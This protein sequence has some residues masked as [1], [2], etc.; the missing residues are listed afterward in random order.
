MKRGYQAVKYGYPAERAPLSHR[1]LGLCLYA[2]PTARGQTDVEMRYLRWTPNG[3]LL[4]VGCGS[5]DW[6]LTMRGW[7]WRVEG[8]DFDEK[9]VAMARQNG[10]D[11]RHGALEQEGFPDNT[12][13]AITLSHV[14]EHVPDPALTLA[15]CAR[16]LKPG[17]T[18][19]VAT[20]N[21][22]SL[23]H[24]YFGEAWRGLEPP[25]HLHI[26]SPASIRRSLNLAGF[27]NVSI[28]PQI[29]TSVIFESYLLSR[30][31]RGEA[32]TSG[33]SFAAQMFTQVFKTL[34]L[35][36]IKIKPSVSDCMSAIA[37]K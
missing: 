22:A 27:A 31:A 6:L 15:E 16:I 23:T 2:L 24:R 29:A 9:A 3:R 25:R 34:E 28:R 4:D 35:C 37:V 7:G 8:L 33:R 18:L 10:L 12:F 26:F 32:V 5:G 30:G 1:L 21:N 20:P 19:V 17:G 11:V 36:L 14:I 13:D